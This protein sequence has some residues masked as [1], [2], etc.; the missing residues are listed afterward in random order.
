VINHVTPH[1]LTTEERAQTLHLKPFS[2]LVLDRPP[3]DYT[4]SLGDIL[5][6]PET[7]SNPPF[8]DESRWTNRESWGG[9]SCGAV[10]F[11][12]PLAAG[13]THSVRFALAAAAE[14]GDLAAIRKRM[15]AGAAFVSAHAEWETWDAGVRVDLPDVE[16]ARYIN[17]FAKHQIRMNCVTARWS[18]A[19]ATRN[20]VQDWQGASYLV[21]AQSAEAFRAALKAQ[22]ADGFIP[23]GFKTSAFGAIVHLLGRDFRDSPVWFP[24]A[25]L[26]L[27]ENTGDAGFLQEVLPYSDGGEATVIDH[28]FNG[29]KFLA[30]RRGS[31]GLI[32]FG[33]GDWND[34]LSNAGCQGRGESSWLSFAFV[35][36]CHEF[37]ELCVW[38]GTPDLAAA[39]NQWA[40]ELTAALNLHAW[41]GG[42]YVRG[43][44]DDGQPFGNAAAAEGRI[45]LETQAFAL[46]ARA[47]PDERIPVLLDSIESELLTDFGPRLL[48][49]PYTKW[50]EAIGR[51]TVDMPG[52]KENGSVYCHAAMFYAAALLKAGRIAEGC[53]QLSAILPTNPSHPVEVSGQNPAYIPNSY[54]APEV[55]PGNGRGSNHNWT[56]TAAWLLLIAIRDVLGV[57]GTP[58]GLTIVPNLPPH[59]PEAGITMPFRGA[60]ISLRIT[61]GPARSLHV[62]GRP[63]LPDANIPVVPGE[64]Y[65]LQLILPP[66]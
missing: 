1:F 35:A 49:P 6:L 60:Q 59:W 65:F 56:G 18:Q 64:N 4:T 19:P 5:P 40:D 53:A 8:L 29:L 3:Q 31:H 46:L 30:N 32:L 44:T 66:A 51:I 43:F 24:S 16:L 55:P 34:Q 52:F 14:V 50:N 13:A 9:Q 10:R 12:I 25:I 21:P 27:L 54:I 33:E 42:W 36:A 39:P 57:R 37:A 26:T 61:R 28:L 20:W 62:N 45:Y 63:T 47:V 23:Q 7:A 17:T 38:A 41:D 48:N 11:S 15:D 2:A 22:R 58:E